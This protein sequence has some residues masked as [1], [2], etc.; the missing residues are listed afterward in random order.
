ML[1][2]PEIEEEV[3]ESPLLAMFE[4]EEKQR[5]QETLG[6]KNAPHLLFE[7]TSD[8]GLHIQADS[9]DGRSFLAQ[10]LVNKAVC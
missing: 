6:K 10:L 5:K 9:W 4:H 1:P 7:I 2:Q 3:V 8:D